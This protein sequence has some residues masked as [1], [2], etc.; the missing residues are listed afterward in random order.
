MLQTASF[1]WEVDQNSLHIIATQCIIS[2]LIS[3]HPLAT[4]VDSRGIHLHI[5]G[6]IFFIKSGLVALD[7]GD[8]KNFME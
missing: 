3:S 8:H 2:L 1:Y 6:C 4:H 7:L 5:A